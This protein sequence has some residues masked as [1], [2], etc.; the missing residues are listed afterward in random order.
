ML[1][2]YSSELCEWPHRQEYIG[3]IHGWIYQFV[4]AI[5]Q[6]V[7][8]VNR[9]VRLYIS[10]FLCSFSA[11]SLA[12]A[13]FHFEVNSL[14][15]SSYLDGLLCHGFFQLHGSHPQLVVGLCEGLSSFPDKF[16]SAADGWV[17]RGHGWQWRETHWS[18]ART[19]FSTLRRTRPA[20]VGW[21]SDIHFAGGCVFMLL[22]ADKF[23]VAGVC[24]GLR[25]FTAVRRIPEVSGCWRPSCY[26]P[27]KSGI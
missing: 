22:F 16:A 17:H 13:S 3:P 1:K 11:H 7:F 18:V 6:F 12:V 2:V 4:L 27:P 21:F 14:L 19:R 5:R 25:H 9:P 20:S 8:G 23:R 10:L 24:T 15:L 26:L